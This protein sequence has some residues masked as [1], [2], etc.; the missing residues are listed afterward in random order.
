[1]RYNG[2]MKEN[3][4]YLENQIRQAIEESGLS[5]YALAKCAGVSQGVLSRF[6]AGKRNLTLATASKIVLALELELRPARPRRKQ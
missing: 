2:S 4:T 5:Q 6:I 3:A 1:M